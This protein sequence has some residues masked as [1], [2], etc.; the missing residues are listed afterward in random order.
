[1]EYFVTGGT[2]F[3]GGELVTQLDEEGHEVVALARTPADAD[4]LH[5]LGVEVVEGDVTD[6]DSLRGPMT[7]VDGVFHAAAIYRL[8]VDD[9][10]FLHAVNVDGTRNVLDLVD[11]LD[12]PKAV[13]TSTLAVNSDTGGALVDETYRFDGEHLSVYDRTKAA[14]HD[15][16]NELAE[17]GVPIVTV[18]PGV[19]Y[20]PGDTSQFGDLWRDFLRGDL[21]A[22]PRET[23][24]CFGHVVDTARGHRQAMDHGVPGEDYI[25]AGHPMTLVEALSVGEEVTGIPAPR[26]VHPA[27]FRAAA[28]VAGLLGHVVDLPDDVRAESLRALGGAT[29]LGENRKARRELGLTHRPFQEGLAETLTAFAEEVGVST[30]LAP[31]Q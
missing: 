26:D 27:L 21:P 11:E 1:M 7:G 8:G 31:A 18:M 3:L 19:I 28:P 13:Y 5:D 22:I 20:G 17:D 16:A 15:V 29:Y 4:H 6:R 12:I 10:D 14:A 30:D 25:I 9:A 24:Y 2:G 23:A